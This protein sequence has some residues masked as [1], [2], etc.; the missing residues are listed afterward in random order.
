[1][2]MPFNS[3]ANDYLMVIDE[4]NNIGYFATDR[5]QEEGKVIIYTFIPNEEI[6]PVESQ[7]KNELIRLAKINSIRDTWKKDLDY[8]AYIKDVRTNILNEQHKVKRDFFFVINDNII[9]YTLDDFKNTAARQAFLKAQDLDKQLKTQEKDLD[10]LRYKYSK[11][12]AQ[13]RE[14]I[15]ATILYRENHIPGLWEQYNQ[16]ILNA[17]NLEIR[18][19]RQQQ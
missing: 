8:Q 13:Y 17:R 15:Q 7:N 11:G 12:N 3:I 4:N 9:Y 5:F 16:T 1:M 18:Y 14:S 19:L 10:D 2:G 6:L